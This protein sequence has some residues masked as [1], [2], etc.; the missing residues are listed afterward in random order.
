M[1]AGVATELNLA[2][3]GQSGAPLWEEADMAFVV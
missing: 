2:G 3:V 1:A